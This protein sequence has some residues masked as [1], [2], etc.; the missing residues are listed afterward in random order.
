[1]EPYD[2]NPKHIQH[3]LVRQI[4]NDSFT[5]KANPI[6]IEANRDRIRQET[7]GKS[8]LR[9]SSAYDLAETSGRA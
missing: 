7:V 3:R 6:R 4:Q 1:M 9:L 8:P 2:N 5:E